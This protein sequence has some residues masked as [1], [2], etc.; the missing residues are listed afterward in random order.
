MIQVTN[1]KKKQEKKTYSEFYYLAQARNY[2]NYIEHN[3]GD[4]CIYNIINQVCEN[5]NL[6]IKF[7]N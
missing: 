7:T 2:I 5:D 6:V 3:M 4:F 1:L